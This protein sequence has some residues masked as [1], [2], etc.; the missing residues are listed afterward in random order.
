MSRYWSPQVQQLSPYIPGEQPRIPNLIKLNTNE[1]PYGPSP[2][3]MEAI[4]AANNESLRLYPDPQAMALK[5][6]LAKYADLNPEQVFVGNGSDEVLA[7]AFQA[8]FQGQAH[9]LLFPE[10]TYSFYPV[11]CQLYQVD[12]KML[13]LKADFTLPLADYQ[14][15]NGGIIFPNPNAP[16]GIALSQA[17]IIALLE[18][19]RD[20]VV[21]I[22]E[23]YVDFGTES[24]QSLV[25]RFPNLLVTQTFSKSW[26]LAGLRVGFAFGHPDLIEALN[27]VK[28]SFNSYPLDRLAL[29]GAQAALEDLPYYQALNQ[30][31]IASREQLSQDLTL[32][33]FE[34]LP[35]K[36]NFVF[37]RHSHH[38]AADL[39]DQ[40]RQ[41]AILVR[42]FKHPQIDQFLRITIGNKEQNQQL[43]KT[44]T[45]IIQPDR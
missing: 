37:A 34:V 27:R 14:Q 23:A 7:M 10:I 17:A 38:C 9:P 44:I 45:Q 8:F 32:L 11:Y 5:S 40:L 41:N 39:A 33:G 16:T 31:I 30:K 12:Y 3:V 25:N 24:A 13:P 22:D 26:A 20:S 19:N 6:A 42:H 21:I 29:V 35:S 43:I 28:D 15:P 1:S 18:Q 2:R 36:A 4:A